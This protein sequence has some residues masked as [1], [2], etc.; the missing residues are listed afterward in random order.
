MKVILLLGLAVSLMLVARSLWL[1][2]RH[3]LMGI[4][5]W[6]EMLAEAEAGGYRLINTWEL[7]ALERDDTVP[8]LLVDTRRTRDYRS[9]HIPGAVNFHLITTWWGKLLARRSFARLLGT[10]RDRILVFY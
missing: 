9:G 7:A 5:S 2:N 10:D 8:T 1:F 4:P 3:R 6:E